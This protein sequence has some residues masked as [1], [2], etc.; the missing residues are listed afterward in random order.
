MQ[1]ECLAGEIAPLGLTP[2][3]ATERLPELVR[4]GAVVDEPL[5]LFPG[6]RHRAAGA[7]Q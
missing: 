6:L 5:R 1:Q 3:N 4:T 2:E 7:P